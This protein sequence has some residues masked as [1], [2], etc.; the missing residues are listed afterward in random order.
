MKNYILGFVTTLMVVLVMVPINGSAKE[1]HFDAPNVENVQEKTPNARVRVKVIDI[2]GIEI[3]P[4]GLSIFFDAK[5][6]VKQP[7]SEGIITEVGYSCAED[8]SDPIYVEPGTEVTGIIT[9]NNTPFSNGGTIIVT[10]NDIDPE[11][12]ILEVSV[13]VTIPLP[14]EAYY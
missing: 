12:T 6:R 10:E 11:G 7:G 14:L 4:C 5:I 9:I 8:L 2:L 13:T 3:S 1:A